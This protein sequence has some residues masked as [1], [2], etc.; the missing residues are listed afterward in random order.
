M[1]LDRGVFYKEN[2]PRENEKG[3]LEAGA[4]SE[5]VVQGGIFE[6]MSD[7][8]IKRQ[9]MGDLISSQR[10]NKHRDWEQEQA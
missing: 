9:P 5:G 2:K 6:E 4:V 3:R 7:T 10:V 8:K 1:T